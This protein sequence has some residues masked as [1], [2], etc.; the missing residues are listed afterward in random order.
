[1]S[2]LNILCIKD[3]KPGHEKQTQAL[4]EGINHYRSVNTVNIAPLGN[5]DSLRAIV[6]R[7]WPTA[8]S[9]S[10]F[11]PDIVIGTG[12]GTHFSVLAAKKA[13]N[14]KA[15]VI[16]N[17]SFPVKLFDG[18][19]T[20]SHDGF[21]P[22][23]NRLTTPLALAPLVKSNPN[24]E[25]GLFLI[26]GVNKHF[27]WNT[28]VL[29]DHIHSITTQYP[30][31]QWQLTTSRRTPVDT[32]NKLKALQKKIENEGAGNLTVFDVNDLS[33][34]WLI[35]TM[36]KASSIW[37]TVDSASMLAESMNTQATIGIIDL[38]EKKSN[39]KLAISRDNLIKKELAGVISQERYIAPPENGKPLNSQIETAE[40]LLSLL[41]L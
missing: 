21:A 33:Q 1:M 37:V 31:R 11:I 23:K 2:D 24:Q 40:K 15:V 6:F 18:V 30:K 25:L 27:H 36:V 20:P 29:I 12:H 16:M 19:I 9:D 5:L 26:G 22:G 32:L 13:F 7:T 34:N 38:E 14:A 17:P 8:I 28:S 10:E 39:N 41:N 4:I 3:G 35:E